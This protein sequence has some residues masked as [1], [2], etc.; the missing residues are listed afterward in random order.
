[1]KKADIA[2]IVL[3]ASISVMT[4]FAI[5]SSMSF[6]K[7]DPNGVEVQTIQPISADIEQPDEAVFNDKA[8]NPTV[9]TVIGGE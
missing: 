7:V 2:M 8:I 6:L 1:M 9:K 4:A 5:A 3:V